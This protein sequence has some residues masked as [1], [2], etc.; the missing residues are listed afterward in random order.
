[1]ETISVKLSTV[2]LNEI[3]CT[4]VDFGLLWFILRITLLKGLIE[5]FKYT[6]LALW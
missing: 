5:Q 1:M 6:F 3:L 2:N 4:V